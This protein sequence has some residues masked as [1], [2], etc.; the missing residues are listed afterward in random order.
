[1]G[2]SI[3]ARMPV[4]RAV[5]INTH[6]LGSVYWVSAQRGF[7]WAISG[8]CGHQL[9]APFDFLLAV[10]VIQDTFANPQILGRDFE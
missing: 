2:R 4:A 1:M 8:A 10:F 6:D 9:V 5:G 3:Q 7:Q